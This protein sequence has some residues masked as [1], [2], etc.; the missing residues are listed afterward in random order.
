MT[1]R[2]YLNLVAY[3][4][5]VVGH[6]YL[7][8][9]SAYFWVG[10]FEPASFVDTLSPSGKDIPSTAPVPAAT[11]RPP[12]TCLP[13]EPASTRARSNITIPRF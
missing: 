12:P 7:H 6:Q 9:A 3:V 10:S 1:A 4:G 11:P 8:R 13:D 5:Q 2:P